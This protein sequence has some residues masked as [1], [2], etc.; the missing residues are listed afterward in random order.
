MNDLE[1][2]IL[3]AHA[4]IQRRFSITGMAQELALLER[5]NEDAQLYIYGYTL[6]K[7]KEEKP[8]CQ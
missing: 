6:P 4:S 2:E 5:C 1:K 7:S 8:L 3:K